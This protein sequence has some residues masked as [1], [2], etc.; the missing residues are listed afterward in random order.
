[1]ST[2]SHGHLVRSAGTIGAW[3]G[4]SRVLGFIRDLVIAAAFGTGLAAEAFVVSFRIPN[5]LR[6]LVGEG[7]T[8]AAFVPVLT[9]CRQKDPDRFW[10]LA[11]TLF[12][13]M[14]GVLLALSALGMLFTEQ[15]VALIAPGFLDSA[16]PEKFP[17]TVRLTRVIFPYLFLI[18]LSALAMGILHTLKEFKSSAFG[19]ALLNLSLIVAGVWFERTYGPMALVVAVLVGG[20]LQLACQVWPL[21]RAGF[22]FAPAGGD[23]EYT[24][25]IGR[26]LV[27]RALGSALYQINVFVDS[28][29][30][31]FERVV[32]SGGQSALYYSN[33]LFQLPLAIF[34]IALAQAALP[35]FSAQMVSGDREGFRGAFSVTMRSV[36]F[37]A[38][39]A[40]TGL[41][42]LARPIVRVLFEHGR[43]D[44]Y[45]TSITS[46]ALFFY[47]FGLV[48]CC[49]IKILV[50]AFYAMQDT[51]TPVR[52]MLVSVAFNVVMSLLL[53]HPLGVGGLALASTL[54]ATLNGVLL[55]RA[56][57]RRV[58]AL[59]GRRI[60]SAGARMLG[61]CAAMA[62]AALAIEQVLLDR[63]LDGTRLSQ[64]LLLAGLIAA[65]ALVYYGACRL[66]RVEEA[67][68]IFSWSPNP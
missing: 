3:T 10:R 27:P 31:S 21:S 52:T 64:S 8:N 1:M 29:L 25:K 66:L 5:L 24:R 12:W 47:A 49:F 23:G 59:D 56:L 43:F 20:V 61:A 6:D 28:V 16:D 37:V 63:L 68:K 53:M 33:R 40:S 13:T 2:H 62:L 60:L 36:L 17:L 18:G 19:P 39:P 9:E 30:A 58:G 14:T 22:R 48:S 41:V 50:N 42:V 57:S 65:A 4:L 32:G 26:L 35:T 51:R 15:I 55:Y 11:A 38:L 45:S 67:R 7:A 34:G 54:S 46:S 44:A